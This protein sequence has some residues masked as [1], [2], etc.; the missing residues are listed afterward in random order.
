MLY[1]SV[2]GI[3]V[4]GLYC[5]RTCE[6]GLNSGAFRIYLLRVLQLYS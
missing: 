6:L 5:Y 3:A 2:N 4:V 1:R